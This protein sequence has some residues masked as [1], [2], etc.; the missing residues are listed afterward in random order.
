MAMPKR[1][2]MRH[3]TCRE[4]VMVRF[5]TLVLCVAFT[6]PAAADA[7]SDFYAGRQVTLIIGSAPGGGY[8]VYARAVARHMG[9]HI[10]GNP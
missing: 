1:A 6:T 4:D 2:I 7:V 9:K 8:D 5:A 3:Y 10:P